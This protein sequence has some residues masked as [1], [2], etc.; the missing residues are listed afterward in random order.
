MVAS[1]S[2]L[3]SPEFSETRLRGNVTCLRTRQPELADLLDG[4]IKRRVGEDQRRVTLTDVVHPVMTFFLGIGNGEILAEFAGRECENA[5]HAVVIERSEENLF[6]AFG[7]IDLAGLY[8]RFD[9]NLIFLLNPD[10]LQLRSF[11]FDYFKD[12][13][14]LFLIESVQYIFD[15]RLTQ[16][17]RSFYGGCVEVFEKVSAEDVVEHYSSPREHTMAGFRNFLTFLQKGAAQ[18]GAHFYRDSLSGIPAVIISA[19]PSLD[20]NLDELAKV[21]GRVITICA[22]ICLKACRNAG[23]EPTFITAIDRAEWIAEFLNTDNRSSHLLGAPHIAPEI[24]DRFEGRSILCIPNDGLFRWAVPKEETFP[25]GGSVAHLGFMWAKHVGANP[26]IFV[27]QDF[28]VDC[29]RKLIYAEKVLETV[30]A[31]PKFSNS[32]CVNFDEYSAIFGRW[33]RSVKGNL[34]ENVMTGLFDSDKFMM[35]KLIAD[36][37]REV[38]NASQGGAVINGTRWM[39]LKEALQYCAPHMRSDIPKLLMER[40]GCRVPL[41]REKIFYSDLHERFRRVVEG[42][43]DV[44]GLA[45]EVQQA[46]GSG[47]EPGARYTR[48]LK[49]RERLMDVEIFRSFVL[50]FIVSDFILHQNRVNRIPKDIKDNSARYVA[51]IAASQG[52]AEVLIRDVGWLLEELRRQSALGVF[53]I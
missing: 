52:L 26:I 43:E 31:I 13:P 34:G 3:F 53:K 49:L 33:S 44:Q 30:K 23:F 51:F 39:P 46:C 47:D 15:P 24:F 14:R 50:S 6:E 8:E 25:V 1:V 16:Q 21:S 32:W 27:G 41:D 17:E 38:I 28:A 35:E 48:L 29:Q 7:R 45:F 20:H 18:A 36:S 10:K 5:R 42:L 19:G 11:F 12:P 22:D 2:G 37:K 4:T 40:K 9:T